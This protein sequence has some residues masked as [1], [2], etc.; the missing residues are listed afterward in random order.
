MRPW[1]PLVLAVSERHNRAAVLVADM[2]E[3]APRLRGSELRSTRSRQATASTLTSRIN[4]L[5]LADRNSAWAFWALEDVW[6]I[7]ADLAPLFMRDRNHVGHVSGH[8]I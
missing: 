8:T 1:I 7:R 4:K 3:G 5:R 2:V 6:N